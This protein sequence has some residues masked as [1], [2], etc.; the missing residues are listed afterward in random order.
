MNGVFLAWGEG[1]RQVTLEG[2]H[3][4][5]LTPTILALLDV[6]IPE[7]MDGRVIREAFQ[8]AFWQGKEIRY[9]G[10]EE[11]VARTDTGLSQ[12]EEEQIHR[13]LKGLGYV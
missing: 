2:I 11:S 4:T 1:V 6:P 13:R 3:M 10:V 5:D 9:C 7:D 12:E 8:E